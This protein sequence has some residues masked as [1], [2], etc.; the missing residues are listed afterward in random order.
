[1]DAAT[2]MKV[3]SVWEAGN[4]VGPMITNRNDK[5]LQALTL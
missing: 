4:V 1:M 3:G 5:L 2:S